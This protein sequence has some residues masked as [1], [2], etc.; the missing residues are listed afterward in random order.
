M[1]GNQRLEDLIRSLH[2]DSG[3]RVCVLVDEYDNPSSSF[4]DLE[5]L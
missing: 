3:Q 1:F 2:R 5:F 4:C